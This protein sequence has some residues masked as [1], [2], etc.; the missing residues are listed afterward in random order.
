MPVQVRLEMVCLVAWLSCPAFLGFHFW[1]FTMCSSQVD[2]TAK[3]LG[4]PYPL[5]PAKVARTASTIQ[6]T[7]LSRQPLAASRR[8]VRTIL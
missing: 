8:S 3:Q 5:V 6:L 1:V 4:Y 7:V 2:R